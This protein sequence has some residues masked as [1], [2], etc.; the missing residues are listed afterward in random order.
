[1]ITSY[2]GRAVEFSG[3]VLLILQPESIDETLRIIEATTT[4]SPFPY[5]SFFSTTTSP[6]NLY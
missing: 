2:L 1:M 3:G 6:P 4:P 5:P